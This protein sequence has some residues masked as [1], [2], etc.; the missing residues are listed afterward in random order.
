[1]SA[2]VL[3]RLASLLPPD[4]LLTEPQQLGA[5]ESDGLTAFRARPLA[6]AIPATTDE[7]IALV[8]FC[9]G[10]KL[11]FVA[12]GSGTSLSGGSLPVAGGVVIALNRLDRILRLDP[13]QRVAVVE[14]GVVN[15]QVTLAAAPH[16]L[17]YAPDPSSQS[18]C[19]I[20]GNVAF[21][22]GGAHCLKYGMTSNHVLGLKAVL[23]TGEVVAWGGESRE[24]IGPDW[25][26]LFT[27]N[28]GLFGIAI[29][30]TLQLLARA[31]CFHTV[32]AG[33]RT[34]EQAGDAVSAIIASGL[35]PGAIEI[36]DALALQA[37]QAAV[38][39]EYPPGCEAVLIVELEGPRETV[40]AERARLDDIIAA[41][42]PVEARPAR[43][44]EERQAI[45]K[46]R[47]SA[48]SA[49]GRLSPDFIV[50]DG[51]VPRRRL[52]EA[53]RRIHQMAGEAG[54]RCGNVFHAG[55]GNLHPLILFDGRQAG[56][57]ER[58]E[59]LAGRIIRMCVEMGGSI[60]GEHGVGMEKRDYLGL[61]FNPDEM[62]CLKRVRA[63][64]DPMGIANPGKMFPGGDGSGPPSHG[65]H[66]LEKAGLLSRV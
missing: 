30:I 36:M 64:Y 18:I 61:M 27:G 2:P 9:H 32:L 50:Q 13:A 65:L 22:A 16:G 49:V 44:A 66:P 24:T 62:E 10:E 51:V 43:D 29:E 57:L 54:I 58:A 15:T 39:A 60:T 17:R 52:G 4:R 21:N 40:A 7:V 47:K 55:D 11:P 35:L 12:R 14:P 48:F 56:A 46:G 45:W 42:R 28:E 38:H 1:M 37:A 3:N 25:C 6:V 5:Y 41:S 31:E 23:A 8:R 63:A 20:G 19:T 59:A 53:L 26:G 33:Y 34:L